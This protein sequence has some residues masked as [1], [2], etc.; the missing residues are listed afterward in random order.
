MEKI[1]VIDH[2]FHK[3]TK[4]FEFIQDFLKQNYE[5]DNFW[6]ESW[7]GG[8]QVPIEIIN[9][10]KTVVFF[11]R[12]P[13]IP[14]LKNIKGNIIWIPMY[15]GL[16]E[17]T[18]FWY[19][20][21]SI[22]IKL[23]CFS[24][25]VYKKAQR[26]CITSILV[27]YF[28]NP[29]DYVQVDNYQSRRVFFWFREKSINLDTMEILF[30]NE[31]I[32]AMNVLVSPDSENEI[33]AI[34]D[35]YIK[36][37]NISIYKGFLSPEKYLSLISRNNIFIAPRLMEGMG[38]SF[39]EAMA[40][41]HCVIAN[42]DAT[43]NEYII[44]NINGILFDARKPR[45]IELSNFQILGENAFH[46][47]ENGWILWNKSIPEILKFV[48]SRM[49]PP[50]KVKYIIKRNLFFLSYLIYEITLKYVRNIKHAIFFRMGREKK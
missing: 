24:N 19:D 6:D 9:Q 18:T 11:Q 1:C 10:Y 17:G 16:P 20:L 5:L 48:G 46:D 8:Q 29:K 38:M 41:G 32:D 43:M 44:D 12:I 40:S 37:F 25:K 49:D 23:I 36:K 50:K 45:P 39:L 21:S 30:S 15:D 35:E 28:R 13:A 27:K 31:K 22:P 26:F 3:K 14:F 33:M 4:S 47:S 2:S 34:K 7:N 42:N